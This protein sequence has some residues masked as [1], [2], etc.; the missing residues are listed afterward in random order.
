MIGTQEPHS[1]RTLSK[2]WDILHN[3]ILK[4]SNNQPRIRDIHL[5]KGMKY[6][7]KRSLHKF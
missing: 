7:E 4:N 3:T 6:K 1:I 2:Y 5:E